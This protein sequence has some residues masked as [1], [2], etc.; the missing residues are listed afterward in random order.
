[1]PTTVEYSGCTDCCGGGIETD[2]C[3]DDPVVFDLV[4]TITNVS[5]CACLA[6]TVNLSWDGVDG[7]TGTATLCSE[8]VDVGMKCQGGNWA[9]SLGCDTGGG[10]R[11]GMTADACAPFQLTVSGLAIAGSCCTGSVDIVVTE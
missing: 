11:G 9:V 6:G 5:S 2:C 3:P 7:W 8:S 4:A 10:G 1:M